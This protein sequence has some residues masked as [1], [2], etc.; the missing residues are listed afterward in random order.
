MLRSIRAR[1]QHIQATHFRLVLFPLWFGVSLIKICILFNVCEAVHPEGVLRV[2]WVSMHLVEGNVRIG[3][4][5]EFDK[6]KSK[7]TCK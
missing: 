3:S 2:E 6:S 7:K 5:A 4:I 1:I